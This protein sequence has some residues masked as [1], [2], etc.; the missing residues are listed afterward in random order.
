M[1]HTKLMRHQAAIYVGLTFSEQ[2]QKTK[3]IVATDYQKHLA[4]LCNSYKITGFFFNIKTN[5]KF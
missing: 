4:T 3:K 1:Q 2:V 5:I